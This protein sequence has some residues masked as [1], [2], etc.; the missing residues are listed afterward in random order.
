MRSAPIFIA[1]AFFSNAYA[2]LAPW[3]LAGDLGR[4]R[5]THYYVAQQLDYALEPADQPLL[6]MEDETLVRVSD[7]YKRAVDIEGT[8][9]LIDGR[10]LNF[11][12]V[13]QGSVR[14]HFSRHPYGHG[15]GNC[16][17]IPFHTLAVDPS[18][19][20]LGSVVQIDETLGMAL[21]DGTLH[22]GLWR[23]EDVG[24][25]IKKDRIDLFVGA[26]NQGA[27]LSR[28]GITHLRPLTVRLVSPPEPGGCLEQRPE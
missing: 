25:A 9:K 1:W 11:A 5:N 21:P 8:G 4:F 28:A 23:A 15:V 16:P 26:G 14:Y 12:G 19:I 10:V 2:L 17:L 13:K 20:A 24:G 22:D 7:A 27:W 6:G 18:E 3:A